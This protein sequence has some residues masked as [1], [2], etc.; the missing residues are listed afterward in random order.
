VK[1]RQG[2]LV[3]AQYQKFCGGSIVDLVKE[4]LQGSVGHG[5]QTQGRLT[6]F[7]HSLSHAGHMLGAIVRMEA[8][9]QL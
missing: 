3:N 9:G 5:L 4:H 6:H 8:K 2:F 1:G 7:A